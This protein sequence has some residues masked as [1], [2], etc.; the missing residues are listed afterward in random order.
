[1]SGIRSTAWSPVRP[2][3]EPVKSGSTRP[4]GPSAPPA[5]AHTGG[6]PR[7]GPVPGPAAPAFLKQFGQQLGRDARPFVLGLG[8]STGVGG[9]ESHLDAPA[10]ARQKLGGVREQVEHH[11]RQ[12]V[13]VGAQRPQG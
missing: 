10:N 7:A 4:T 3:G 8:R 9:E 5:G 12:A 6:A 11:L 1:M 2:V 13:A